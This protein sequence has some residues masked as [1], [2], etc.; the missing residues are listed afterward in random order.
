[1]KF[2]LSLLMGTALT[3]IPSLSIAQDSLDTGKGTAT[4]EGT[5]D[6]TGP[7]AAPTDGTKPGVRA[8][9]PCR[10]LKGQERATCLRKANKGRQAARKA[11]KMQEKLEKKVKKMMERDKK[12]KEKVKKEMKREIK[13]ENVRRR[14]S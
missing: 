7:T 8:S 11:K 13:K 14:G 6:D 5:T 2:L 9:E 3:L 1:M 12:V 10:D 4:Q